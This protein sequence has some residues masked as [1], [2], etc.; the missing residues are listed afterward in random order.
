MSRVGLN[1]IE[2]PSGVDV[3]I[4]D[5]DVVVKGPKGTLEYHIIY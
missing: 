3:A 2:L 4:E 5:S 1:P